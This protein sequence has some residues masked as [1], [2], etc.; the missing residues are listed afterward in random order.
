MNSIIAQELIRV[1]NLAKEQ[2]TVSR[3][4]ELNDSKDFRAETQ[5]K[6]YLQYGAQIPL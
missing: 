5:M 4:K 3:G 6:S 2:E 1:L